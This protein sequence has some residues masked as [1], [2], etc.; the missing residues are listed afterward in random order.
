M[1]E[2]K[3]LERKYVEETLDIVLGVGCLKINKSSITVTVPW[4][5]YNLTY[6]PNFE[7]TIEEYDSIE[8]NTYYCTG[9]FKQFKK[10]VKEY[11]KGE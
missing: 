8:H 10:K 1:E 3:T 5:Y 6:N 11:I 2:Q 4:G 7:E 9:N